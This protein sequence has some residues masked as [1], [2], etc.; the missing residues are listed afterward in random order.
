MN[1]L[2]NKTVRA[3]VGAMFTKKIA[4]ITPFA[5]SYEGRMGGPLS[6][7]PVATIYFVGG[8]TAHIPETPFP[9]VEV[10]EFFTSLLPLDE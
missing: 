2:T 5:Y 1:K 9:T 10:K 3:F 4:A 7:Q 8:T 6:V